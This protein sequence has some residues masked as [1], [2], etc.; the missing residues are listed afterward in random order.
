MNSEDVQNTAKETVETGETEETK[1]NEETNETNDH[2]DK[3][4]KKHLLSKTKDAFIAVLDENGNGE[5]DIADVIIKGMKMPGIR[6]NRDEFLRKQ[7]FKLYP[8]EIIDIAVNES[9]LKA[10]IPQKQ[11]DKIADEVIKFERSC[12]SGISTVLGMPGGVTAVAT[13]SVDIAQYYGYLLRATQKLMYLYGF[14]QIATDEGDD[15]FDDEMINT[16]V[17]CLGVMYGVAGANAALR[18]LAKNLAKG[19]ERQLIKKALTKGFLYPIVKKV[20]KYFAVNMTKQMYAA[21]FR[22]AIPVAGGIVGGGITFFSFKPCCNN[23]KAALQN[24][25]LS[26]P[27]YTPVLE[28]DIADIVIEADDADD[29]ATQDEE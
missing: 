3:T 24:T 11:I 26:N 4:P 20:A 29:P 22:S 19:V 12:V 10:H 15:G 18:F 13:A 23:L 28:D 9:P 1:E 8:R 21:F 5:I 7:L 17:L 2:E 16:M 14:P 27:N 25:M 6:I